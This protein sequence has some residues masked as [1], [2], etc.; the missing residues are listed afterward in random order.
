M[1]TPEF[2]LL[3]SQD[4]ILYFKMLIMVALFCVPLFR[5][6][7]KS[8]LDPFFY[9][10]VSAVF[11]Y[12]VPVF[13]Y[14]E[15]FCSEKY[16]YYFL[17]SEIVFWIVLLVYP[18]KNITFNRKKIVG[19]E[20]YARIVFKLAFIIYIASELY[21][22]IYIGIPLF[23]DYRQELYVGTGYGF[24]GRFSSFASSYVILYSY[25]QILGKKNKKYVAYFVF[26]VITGLL[27][28]SKGAILTFLTWY[29]IYEYF[30]IGKKPK[31][32][33]K[34]LV[35]VLCFPIAVL[36]LYKGS[37]S[38]NVSGAIGDF[39][40]RFMA[41][42]DC[43]WMAYPNGNIDFIH[44]KQPFI[45]LF[46]GFLAPLRFISYDIVEPA[47]GNQ[48]FWLVEPS[49]YGKIAGPNARLAISGW[50]YFGWGGIVFAALSGWL[51]AFCIY[52]S[53]KYFTRSIFGVFL[54]GLLFQ[55]GVSYFT[56]P[57]LFFNNISSFIM[58][59]LLYG[60][61]VIL[62]TRLRTTKRV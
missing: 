2:W 46:S 8:I 28:G 25:Y 26:I 48:L 52:T 53:K 49:E 15:G 41:N 24:L 7:T 23:M 42:G 57:G 17:I 34:Y 4:T 33:I 30:Y 31:V 43:Y 5:C 40:F 12:T 10:L 18:T 55:A 29:F 11:A 50:C 13:L 32:K 36:L 6:F 38:G 45:S 19:E 62:L 59:I 27:S 39:L 9:A 22:Y 56:D 20:A 3:Y 44:I 37:T 16:F 14:L 54:Y 60:F 47:I 21:T 35:L 51:V 1:R 58:N 61:V